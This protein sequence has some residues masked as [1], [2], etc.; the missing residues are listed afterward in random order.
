MGA[1]YMTLA[2]IPPQYRSQLKSIYLVLLFKSHILKKCSL[3]H[4]LQP[5]LFD[6]KVLENEGIFVTKKDGIH[7][8]KGSIA[9]VLGD[10]L[11]SHAM[12]GFI[13]C[14]T[15]YRICRFCMMTKTQIHSN[16]LAKS[17]PR[18]KTGHDEQVQIVNEDPSQASTYGVK[19]HS[20]LHEL[21]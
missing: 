5:F 12:G 2:N 11:G 15:S 9:V 7:W 16:I 8:F 18:T 13:E 1:F 19:S 10:N 21:K 14:F 17:Q 6:L 4:I 20:P 3:K